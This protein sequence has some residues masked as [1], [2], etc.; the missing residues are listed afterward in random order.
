M[1]IGM[2]KRRLYP[3]RRLYGYGVG[4]CS[5]E[6][7]ARTEKSDLIFP[8]FLMVT[9]AVLKGQVSADN[10]SFVSEVYLMVV[11]FT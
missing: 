2:P 1:P 5:P 4:P 3:A 8:V 11:A 10:V 7:K 6:R 9:E